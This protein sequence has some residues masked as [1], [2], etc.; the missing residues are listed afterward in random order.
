MFNKQGAGYTCGGS[1]TSRK[2]LETTFKATIAK[3]AEQ[4]QTNAKADQNCKSRPVLSKVPD[5][6]RND[7]SSV[8][9]FNKLHNLL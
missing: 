4:L 8:S 7:A 6:C 2:L 5:N 9:C 1:R 3:A